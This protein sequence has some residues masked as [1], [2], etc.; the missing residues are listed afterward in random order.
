MNIPFLIRKWHR[1]LA[2]IIG[3]QALVWIASGV[4]MVTVDLDYIHGDQLVQKMDEPIT[5]DYS[6]LIS[7][8]EVQ[9]KYPTA[10]KIQLVLWLGSAHYRINDSDGSHLLGAKTGIL[11]S[12]LEKNDARRVAEYHFAQDGNINKITLITDSKSAPSEIAARSLPLWQVSFD[13]KI[14]SNFYIDPNSGVL[15]T[16]RHKYWRTFDFLWML[17]IMDYENR[18]DVNNLLLIISS[19]LGIILSLC[20]FWL[21]FYSF[22]KRPLQQKGGEE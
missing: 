3:L 13:D 17:H 22:K 21:L 4:Y 5:E 10:H 8:S 12:P 20:G 16:R 6:N 19:I 14:A 7:F 15:V 9:Q 18:T 2:L 1:W 11:R